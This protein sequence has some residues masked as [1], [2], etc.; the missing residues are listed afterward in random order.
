MARKTRLPWD[1]SSTGACTLG[2]SRFSRESSIL[3]DEYEPLPSASKYIPSH[4][5]LLRASME[6]LPDHNNPRIPF[7]D[8][9]FTASSRLSRR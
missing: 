9:R 2:I 4:S 5:G 8:V 7:S 3:V 1:L 6:A